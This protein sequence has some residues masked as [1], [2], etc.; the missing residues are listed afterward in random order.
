MG[1]PQ[2][3]LQYMQRSV[4]NIQQLLLLLEGDQPNP[5]VLGQAI[6]VSQLLTTVMKEASTELLNNQQK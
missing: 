1:I 6:E 2:D 3:K 5:Q 4:K